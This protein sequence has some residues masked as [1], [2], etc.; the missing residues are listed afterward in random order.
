MNTYKKQLIQKYSDELVNGEKAIYQYEQEH[1]LVSCC[2]IGCNN[3]CRQAIIVTSFE[4][5]VINYHLSKSLNFKRFF[6][7]R[8][9][10]IETCKTLLQNEIHANSLMTATDV[11]EIRNIQRKYFELNLMCPFNIKGKCSIYKYRPITC[12]TYKNYGTNQDCKDCISPS[13][14]RYFEFVERQI[15]GN[16][17]CDTGYIS[18]SLELLPYAVLDLF[19]I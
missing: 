4:S 19:L 17:F 6:V 18:K 2:G 8:K 1:D 12:L 7:V 15:R 16:I 5:E 9:H 10:I 11:S 3:C 14:S 13:E